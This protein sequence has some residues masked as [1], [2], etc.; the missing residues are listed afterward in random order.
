[1][2][3]LTGLLAGASGLPSLLAWVA[4]S[5]LAFAL[6]SNLLWLGRDRPLARSLYG[7]WLAVAGRFAYYI[8]LPYLAL[9]GWPLQPYRGLLAPAS[10]GLVGLDG[11]WTVNRWLEAAGTGA[12]VGLLALLFLLLAW[13]NANRSSGTTRLSLPVR[14]AWTMVV[15]GLYL[16][17]HW[18]FYRAALAVTVDDLYVGVFWGLGLTYLEWSLSP[19][20]RRAWRLYRG[21]AGEVWL[22]AV[23]ALVA[24]LL[25]LLT[26]N[27]WVCLVVHWA[28]A[29]ALWAVARGQRSE[30]EQDLAAGTQAL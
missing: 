27:L 25:F 22:R 29:L 4:G 2:D 9:G 12:G 30:P 23:L 8:G 15:D 14:P 7:R 19:F 17:V 3:L 26:H 11:S 24:A 21:Q 6:A 20:W 10:L 18:S 16:Q 5:I 13:L 28:L 1:M